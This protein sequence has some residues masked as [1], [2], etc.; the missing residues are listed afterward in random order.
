[1]ANNLS[2]IG[3]V[4]PGNDEF[5]AKMIELAGALDLH[6]QCDA[7]QYAIWR[8]PSGAQLWF[9]ITQ[10]D[11]DNDD[12]RSIHGLTPFF[13]GKSKVDVKITQAIHRSDDNDFEGCYHAWIKVEGA[14][15]P[16]NGTDSDESTEGMYPLVYD[17]VDF[18]L[19]ANRKMP[20]KAKV[21]LSA[22]AREL[23]AYGSKEDFET[24]KANSLALSAKSFIPIGL[25]APHDNNGGANDD[26]ADEEQV[27]KDDGSAAD[28]TS[29]TGK[30]NGAA[31]RKPAQSAQS[32]AAQDL[33]RGDASPTALLTGVVTAHHKL[34]NEET[35]R[36]FHWL[37]VDSFAAQFDV[38]A[39]PD[40]IEGVI[41]VGGVVKVACWMFGRIVD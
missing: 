22:F 41:A 11:D 4:F 33:T 13:E 8:E 25:F 16:G 30:E 7:G 24:D 36:E 27:Q 32:V 21:R 5:A 6:A 39:D 3:F 40:V 18:A 37:L 14:G 9:H 2:T 28:Q 38:I 26:Q 31:Q 12:E 19:F 20:F 34:R 17:A 23:T 35:G 15:E 29:V 1:M 10:D